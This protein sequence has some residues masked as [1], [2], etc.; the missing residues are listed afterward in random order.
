MANV[1]LITGASRGIGAAIAQRF[2]D[3]GFAVAI[4]ARTEHEGDHRLEGS[5]ETT[6]SRIRGTGAKVLPITA[7]LARQADRARIIET[8]ERELGPIDVLVNNAAVTYFEPVL[9]FPE[10]HY[11][12]MFD[13]QVRA[14]FE[15]AQRVL[16]GMRERR[17]GWIL[18]IS[19]RAAIHPSGPPYTSRGGSTVYGM[20]KAAIE[21]FSSGLASEVY[22]DGIAV[23]ALSP[24]GLVPTPGTVF[25]HL[26]DGVAADRL[27]APEVMAEAAYALC[28]G[29]PAR[30]T[31]K[32]TYA[33]PIL[34]ELGVP[35]PT[36]AAKV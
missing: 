28:T 21:R 1:V 7:D 25:H 22:A 15:L 6:A 18:N 31:G 13:V 10:R 26:T 5:L 34:E 32:V 20:C 14:T 9:D 30:V 36:V 11:Q 16:P 4:T 3:G 33:K 24:S 35:V 2:A 29:D 8:V 27:E 23:N 17:R 19:S 12:V